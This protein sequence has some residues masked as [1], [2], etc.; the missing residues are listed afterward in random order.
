[1][2]FFRIFEVPEWSVVKDRHA[3]TLEATKNR[4]RRHAD[5]IQGDF[6]I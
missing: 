2:I 6:T 3:R 5:I 4:I 1:M